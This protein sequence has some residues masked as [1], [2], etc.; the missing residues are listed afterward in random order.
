[1]SQSRLAMG[2]HA[3][4]RHGTAHLCQ[5]L[6]M[7]GTRRVAFH[8]VALMRGKVWAVRVWRWKKTCSTRAC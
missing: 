1:M 4:V 2:C 5:E 3:S 6:E 8:M 7:Q